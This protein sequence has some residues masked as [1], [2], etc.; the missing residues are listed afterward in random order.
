[1][2]RSRR[3]LRLRRCARMRRFREP[4]EAARG[5][6]EPDLCLEEAGSRQRREPV[7]ARGERFERWR[8]GARARDGQALRQ[9]RPTDGRTGFLGQEARVDQQARPI[10]ERWSNGLARTCQCA[11]NA[12]LWAWRWDLPPQARR[13]GGRSG[14]DAPHRRTASRT[15]VLRLAANDLRTQQGRPWGQPQASAAADAADGDRGA[16]SAPRT[17]AKPRPGTRYTPTCCAA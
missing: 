15:S 13:R 14:G 4:G 6:S 16:G 5:A 12:R 2:R 11:A 10:E 7:R 17:P 8:G 3:R 9:D 1:M